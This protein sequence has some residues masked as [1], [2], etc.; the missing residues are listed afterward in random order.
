MTILLET[1]EWESLPWESNLALLSCH[2]GHHK[3]QWA[4][5]QRPHWSLGPGLSVCSTSLCQ[6]HITWPL[7]CFSVSW[8]NLILKWTPNTNVLRTQIKAITYRSWIPPSLSKRQ[9]AKGKGMERASYLP[10]WSL[11]TL[12]NEGFRF[13]GGMLCN[14]LLY[15]CIQIN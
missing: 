15:F 10:R 13:P 14:V 6:T 5:K 9:R 11:R 1:V 4:Q 7:G 8:F 2:S 12:Y 3:Q